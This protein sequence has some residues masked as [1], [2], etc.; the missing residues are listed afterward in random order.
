MIKMDEVNYNLTP[1]EK[2]SRRLHRKGSKYDLILDK[3]LEGKH[4]LVE[5]DVAGKEANY[6]RLQLKKRINARELKLRVSVVNNKVYLE[7]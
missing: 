1:V 6:I 2:K 4:T 7:R 5:V 3:F